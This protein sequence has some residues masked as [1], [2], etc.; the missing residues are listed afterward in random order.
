MNPRILVVE[1]NVVVA[2]NL[3]DRLERVRYDVAGISVS[4]HDAVRQAAETRPDL[5]LMDINLPGKPD[6][7]A[8]AA[9]IHA[10][11]DIPV[12]YLI[13][14]ADEAALLQARATEPYG[15]VLD[16]FERQELGNTIQ[17]ALY[18]HSTERE[19]RESEQRYRNLVENSLQGILVFQGSPPRIV[20]A[21]TLCAE[22][23][24]HTVEELL[25][26][27]PEEVEVLIHPEDRA[28]IRGWLEH[29]ASGKRVSA[30]GQ[31]RMV[32]RDG[33]TRWVECFASTVEQGGKL[34]LQLALVDM[35]K[36]K[37]AEQA[38]RQVRDELEG[39]VEERTAE[40]LESNKL[41]R[42]EMMGH[43][44]AQNVLAQRVEE[45]RILHALGRQVSASLSLDQVLDA[46]LRGI[47]ENVAPDLAI[48]FLR[49]GDEL[50][51]QGVHP[52]HPQWQDR[53]GA[54]RVGD[55][56][57]GLAAR[58]GR[59]LYSSELSRDPRCTRE[60]CK[61]AG[62]NSFAA[63]PLLR[64]AEVIGVLGL[65]SVPRRD[66]GEQSAF[67][68]AL[69]SAIAIGLQNALMHRQIERHAAELEHQVTERKQ[70]EQALL[71]RERLAAMGQLAA[72]LAH[73]INNPLQAIG[74]NLELVLDFPLPDEER[75]QYL[76]TVR[77]EVER[78]MGLTRRMLD[79]ARPPAV[80]RQPV[81]LKEAVHH[82]LS[83]S[84]KQ[85]QHAG[86][87]VSLDLPDPL[88][89]VL[90]SRD[91][92]TQ[93]FLNLIL[94]ALEAMSAGGELDITARHVGDCIELR[95]VDNGPGLPSGVLDRLFE[96]FYTTRKRGIGLGLSISHSIIHQHG[97]TITA[98]NAPGGGA[99]IVLTLPVAPPPDDQHEE[100]E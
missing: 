25:S 39:Q 100:V 72:A 84:G 32:R 40:L 29:L 26:L 66:F 71:Y 85:L 42:R 82:A 10:R 13:G 89:K 16:P 30:N 7:V 52:P 92:L 1:H 83:L 77:G 34:A 20:F 8:V 47:A 80:E 79:F 95:F 50:R 73:E 64:G 68:E 63:L 5:V 24:G 59:A 93:V 58:G 36:L 28:K 45:L 12:V 3:K 23:T 91:Q 53:A 61:K 37:L 46:A 14:S 55:C 94:N 17:M 41:L 75:Q 48:L 65:A 51:L 86:I 67:L 74:S 87:Q 98:S 6:A 78:L 2:N 19:L 49:K 97:G 70:M 57:C 88:P 11:F 99:V 81:S 90:A 54:L 62:M 31:F 21:S 27:S 43:L 35:T 44:Q 76:Q 4:G 15:H 60:E 9:E 33:A 22:I 38:L 96:P 18:K 69:A 56:L